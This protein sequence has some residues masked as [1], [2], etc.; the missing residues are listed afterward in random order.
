[1][2]ARRIDALVR[3]L[4][5]DGRREG[6]E[7]V[8]AVRAERTPSFKVHLLGD[9]AGVWG[10]F[11]TGEFGDALDLVAHLQ[12]RGDK[13]AAFAWSLA[14]LGLAEGGPV[15]H[16]QPREPA[17]R[18]AAAPGAD[19]ERLR[20]AAL[21]LWLEGRPSI[22]DTP[23]EQYLAGRGIDLA[24]LD[25]PPRALRY[26]PACY[27]RETGQRLPAMV[28]TICGEGGRALAT[29]RTWLQQDAAGQWVKA[30]LQAPKMTLGAYPGGSIRL[31]RGASGKPL[32]AALEDEIVL[33]GEGIETSLS[34]A[35]CY[36]ELRVLAGVSISGMG[37]VW[38]PPQIHCVVLLADNDL[39]EGPRRGLQRACERHMDAGREVRIARAPAGKDF[40]D[41]LQAWR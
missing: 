18:A 35:V 38:L 14:W 23:V 21:R 12:F 19:G 31:S 36:P 32:A 20:R 3:E 13:K 30:R 41:A 28:A 5:P 9:K 24:L 37:G 29:H 15:A 22:L 40:N 6:A 16:V 25:R 17:A 39:G 26:H 10:D 7:W 33:I 27:N 34:A 4:L 8:A 11:G 2:L 1:M